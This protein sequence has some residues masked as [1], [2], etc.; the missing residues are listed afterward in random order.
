MRDPLY[1]GIV[2]GPMATRLLVADGATTLLKA[3]LP[4]SPH[5]PRAVFVFAEAL[6]LW[7]GRPC[8]VAIAADGRGAFCATTRWLDTLELMTQPVQVTVACVHHD[9]V[10]ADP[11]PGDGLGSFADVHRLLRRRPAP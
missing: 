7:T 5:H 2:P 11:A 3:R 9:A 4:H 6:T 8:H 10:P 1:V